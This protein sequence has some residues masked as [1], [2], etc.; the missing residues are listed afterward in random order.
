MADNCE[1]RDLRDSLILDRVFFGV[2]DNHVRERLLRVPDLTFEKTL[3]IAR[4]AEATR[5][6]LKE[7]Q[8]L[9]EVNALRNRDEGLPTEKPEGKKPA[10]GGDQTDCKF[11][12]R[13]HVRDR[14]KCP[15]YGQQGNTCRCGN[16]DHFAVKGPAGKPSENSHADQKLHY[17]D[18]LDQCSFAE[19]T[20]DVITH[21][22]PERLTI[23]ERI[24]KGFVFEENICNNQD[25]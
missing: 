22:I 1:F 9:Q 24:F 20:I 16:N 5:N 13:R 6:Q 4:T 11:C 8:N 15:I 14:M 12:G 2:T 17:V 25:V 10:S 21:S 7:I 3:E 18:D 23:P 19:Y